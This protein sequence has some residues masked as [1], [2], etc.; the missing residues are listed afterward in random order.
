MSLCN[1]K[2]RSHCFQIKDIKESTAHE[3]KLRFSEE[4]KV[5]ED[6]IR[7]RL[8]KQQSD[9]LDI[10]IARLEDDF[11]RKKCDTQKECEERI[12]LLKE[13]HEVQCS[14]WRKREQELNE[15]YFSRSFVSSK[16][17][18][19]EMPGSSNWFRVQQQ[20]MNELGSIK[21]KSANWSQPGTH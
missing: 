8:E 3:L 6:A 17:S 2:N 16:Y 14:S 4:L 9:E 15:K 5:S 7:S 19:T 12:S 21:C 20:S 10:V 18:N 11:Q 1:S 13:S